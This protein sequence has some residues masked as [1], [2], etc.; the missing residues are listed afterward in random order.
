MTRGGCADPRS[1]G[2]GGNADGLRAAPDGALFT[3]RELIILSHLVDGRSDA[4]ISSLLGISMATLHKHLRK[5][6]VKLGSDSRTEAAIKAMRE[7]IVK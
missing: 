4:E 3:R 7:G 1:D 2:S 5:I 6:L